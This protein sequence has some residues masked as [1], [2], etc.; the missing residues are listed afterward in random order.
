MK[1]TKRSLISNNSLLLLTEL[2]NNA[3]KLLLTKEKRSLS[4]V[5]LELNYSMN[6]TKLESIMLPKDRLEMKRDKLLA[7]LYNYS[8]PNLDYSRNTLMTD[9]SM[10]KKLR[11]RVL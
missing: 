5:I 2:L 7:R 10:S 9:L 1:S 6:A 4:R 3:K 8:K 11:D